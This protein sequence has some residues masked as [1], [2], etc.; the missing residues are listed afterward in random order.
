MSV[1]IKEV[2]TKKDL[3][4]FVKFPFELYKDNQYWAPPFMSD[5][6]NTLDW[7]TNPAFD[8]S[9]V[10]YWLAYKNGRIAGRIAA[11]I[12]NALIEK[13]K[14]QKAQF[15]WIDFI[16]DEEVS[17]AL[18]DKAEKWAK[19]NGMNS[20][21]GP[22]GFTDFDE[23]GMLVEGF[24]EQGTYPMIYNYPYYPLHLKKLGYEKEVD[25]LE[26][27]VK[28]PDTIPEKIVRV[29]ELIL[30]R[31]K[32]R[33]LE[34]KKAKDIVPYIPGFFNI[35]DEAYSDLFG[36]IPLTEKQKKF[37]TDQYFDFI[38]PEY[39]KFIINEKDEVVAVGLAFPSFTEALRKAKGRKFPFGL[40][41]MLQAIKHPTKLDFYLIGVKKEYIGHGV[42]SIMMNEINKN[43]IK[44]GIKVC[45]TTGELEDNKAVQDMW[46]HYEHRQHKR[47]RCFIKSL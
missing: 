41:Y 47:C 3:K 21:E 22:M 5:E 42:I 40:L 13:W 14:V 12:N 6:I 10:K 18:F 38:L 36:V 8:F 34:A 9:R 25:W 7:N 43:A 23:H 19:E 16:D 29:N 28:V 33:L 37:Y 35:I 46:R 20:I 1:E 45:E 2:L 30:K 24:E 17:K 32:L 44:N 39:S 26:F 31:S 11:I 27:E 15:G 4:K